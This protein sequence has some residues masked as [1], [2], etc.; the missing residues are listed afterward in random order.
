MLLI[1][2]RLQV[3][4][5]FVHALAVTTSGRLFGWGYNSGGS[6]LNAEDALPHATELYMGGKMLV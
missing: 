3:S 5:G 4:C 6:L 1:M 2:P